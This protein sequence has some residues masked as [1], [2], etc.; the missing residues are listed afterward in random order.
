[1]PRKGIE[2]ALL[3]IVVHIRNDSHGSVQFLV[4]K[5]LKYLKI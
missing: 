2:F 5:T 3:R 4:E 1:M